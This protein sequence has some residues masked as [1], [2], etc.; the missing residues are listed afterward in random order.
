[1]SRWE[2]GFRRAYRVLARV[3]Q[4]LAFAVLVKACVAGDEQIAMLAVTAALVFDAQVRVSKL[5]ELVGER[6][7]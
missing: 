5:E 7:K 2:K 1:M 6:D 3:V 4:L